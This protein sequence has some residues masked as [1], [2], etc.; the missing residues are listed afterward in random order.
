MFYAS[1]RVG[2]KYAFE[3]GQYSGEYLIM[4]DNGTLS[5]GSSKGN[6]HEFSLASTGSGRHIYLTATLPSGAVCY[7]SFDVDGN[8][9]ANRC[10][11]LDSVG[12]EDAKLQMRLS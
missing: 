11:P 1:N 6:I 5:L 9:L 10:Q 4:N 12:L 8:P 3:S 2:G 7:V